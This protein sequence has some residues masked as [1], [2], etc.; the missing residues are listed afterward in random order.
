[1]TSAVDES[2]RPRPATGEAC[3][4]RPTTEERVDHRE[5]AGEDDLSAAE[6]EDVA[7]QSPESPDVQLEPDEEEEGH[8][9]E[10]GVVHHPDRNREERDLAAR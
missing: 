10:L 2:A 6:A 3:Q 4:V 8:D 1:M 7:A 9:A 5:Q